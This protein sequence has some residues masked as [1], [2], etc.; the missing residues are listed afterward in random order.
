MDL[1]EDNEA[2]KRIDLLNEQQYK[3]DA[4]QKQID[5]LTPKVEEYTK[6]K[7]SLWEN[8][9]QLQAQIVDLSKQVFEKQGQLDSILLDFSKQN[10]LLD[11]KQKDINNQADILTEAQKVLDQKEVDLEIR[12]KELSETKDS[13][14]TEIAKRDNIY[15]TQNTDLLNRESQLKI[16]L[17]NLKNSQAD[18]N[19]QELLIAGEE[20]DLQNKLNEAL[21]IIAQAQALKDL[22]IELDEKN[23]GL[24]IQLEKVR[25][26]INQVKTTQIAQANKQAELNNREATIKL[27]EQKTAGG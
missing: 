5:E 19:N 9:E 21:P 11:N 24:E 25:L 18:L 26:D 15:T 17:E 2:Q 22:R 16:D 3:F 6:L 8:I 23:A 1:N 12:E 4:L 27:A 10:E 13:S 7:D 14:L 20:E